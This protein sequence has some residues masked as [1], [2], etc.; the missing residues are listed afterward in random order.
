M[1]ENLKAI[2]LC[3]RNRHGCSVDDV[4]EDPALRHEFLE[5]AWQSFSVASERDLLHRL[6]YLRKKVRLLPARSR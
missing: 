3:M 5:A 1:D 4:L 2:Y 6:V